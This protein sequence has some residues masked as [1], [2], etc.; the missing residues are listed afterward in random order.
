VYYGESSEAYTGVMDVGPSNEARLDDLEDCRPYYVAVKAYNAWGESAG[1]SNEVSGWPRP[2]VQS[3]VPLAM[4]QGSQLVLSIPGTNFQEGAA[5]NFDSSS[6]PADITGD[7]LLRLESVDVV[8]CREIQALATVEPMARGFR[9]MP[10]GELEL[11]FEVRNPDSVYGSGPV[12]LAV[13]L[14]PTRLDIDRSD[15]STRDRV[16]GKD[17]VWM[18]YSH[19]AGEGHER[20]NPD[21]DLNGDGTVDG[22]DLAHLAAGFGGCFTGEGWSAEACPGQ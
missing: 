11:S 4:M 21:V 6:L 12:P 3:D 22:E 16:D 5:V 15:S 8:S 19:G 10:I 9:A 14:N 18:S 17:L 1:F 13:A 2:E 7:P 20:Y